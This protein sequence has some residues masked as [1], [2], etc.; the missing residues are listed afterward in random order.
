MILTASGYK[1]K[2]NKLKRPKI[3]DSE[4]YHIWRSASWAFLRLGFY[5]IYLV[6]TLGFISGEHYGVLAGYTKTYVTQVAWHIFSQQT[7]TKFI[8][9]CESGWTR[10]LHHWNFYDIIHLPS[11]LYQGNQGKWCEVTTRQVFSNTY[12]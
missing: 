5:L 9:L 7:L 10:Q 8:S 1:K 3:P 12:M 6:M 4:F 11:G 2:R